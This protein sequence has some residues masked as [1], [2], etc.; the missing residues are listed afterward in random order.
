MKLT[1]RHRIKLC[2]EILTIT[3]GHAHSAF[4][5]N[6]P[7]FQRGYVAGR[8]DSALEKSSRAASG[9]GKAL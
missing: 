4:E 8:K 2:W 9:E 7:I 5:K 3:S 6:L 1:L